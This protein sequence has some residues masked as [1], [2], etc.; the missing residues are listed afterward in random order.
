MCVDPAR[1]EG[2]TNQ[3]SADI[4]SANYGLEARAPVEATNP[5]GE[6]RCT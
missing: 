5:K 6:K 2:L 4:L 3:G 1:S